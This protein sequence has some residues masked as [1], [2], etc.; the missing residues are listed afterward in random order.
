MDQR[1]S[2]RCVLEGTAVTRWVTAVTASG[3]QTVSV[4]RGWFNRTGVRQCPASV[5]R[6][7]RTHVHGAT[8]GRHSQCTDQYVLDSIEHKSTSP[9]PFTH[10]RSAVRYRPRPPLSSLVERFWL[11]TQ[12]PGLRRRGRPVRLVAE[13]GGRQAQRSVGEKVSPLLIS[14]LLPVSGAQPEPRS[15]QR[16]TS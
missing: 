5:P 6:Q 9:G 2:V 11:D 8:Q 10:Q 4:Q 16:S 3:R 12:N 7:A 15:H 13:R 14:V 1:T